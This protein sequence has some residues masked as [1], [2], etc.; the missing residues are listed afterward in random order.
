M[1]RTYHIQGTEEFGYSTINRYLCS[2][3]TYENIV[4]Q[5]CESSNNCAAVHFM[6]GYAAHFCY[7][8]LQSFKT[9]LRVVV[10]IKDHVTALCILRMLG[11]CVAVFHLIYLEPDENL[12]WLR[13]CLYVIDGC[14]QSLKVLPEDIDWQKDCMP[15]DEFELF[16]REVESNRQDRLR[17]IREAEEILKKSPFKDEEAFKQIVEER[18]WKFEEFKTH[19]KKGKNQYSWERMYERIGCTENVNNFSFYSQYAHG[20]SISNLITKADQASIDRVLPEAVGLLDRMC[21]YMLSFFKDYNFRIYAS[22][23]D[24]ETRDRIL[25][26]FDDEHRKSILDW[27]IHIYR[28]LDSILAEQRQKI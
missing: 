22:F 25:A 13:H 20:L 21:Y 17:K 8:R 27:S 14:E 3:Y 5:V 9:F 26:C 24:T 2:L 28:I 11:D 16:K 10:E 15:D 12:R 18:N 1:S 4:K 23:L 6:E 7:I 19:S